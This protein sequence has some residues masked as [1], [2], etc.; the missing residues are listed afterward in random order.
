ML[1]YFCPHYKFHFFDVCGYL[2]AIDWTSRDI[3]GQ[4]Q[5]TQVVVTVCC[6]RDRVEFLSQ[7]TTPGQGCQVWLQ[8]GSD[9]PQ[10]GQVREIF[11]SHFTIFL[12]GQPICTEI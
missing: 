11:R 6:Y 2:N 8:I 10:I 1:S 4:P 9:W 3:S 5:L 12:L 7:Q